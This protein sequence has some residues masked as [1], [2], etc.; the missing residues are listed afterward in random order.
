MLTQRRTVEETM[1]L[2]P[3]RHWEVHLGRL[4]EKPVETM[5]DSHNR[6]ITRLMRQLVP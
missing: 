5:T 6:V 3:D 1:L 4:R 2:E